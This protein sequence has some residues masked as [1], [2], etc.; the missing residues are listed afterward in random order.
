VKED[1]RGVLVLCPV[2]RS[3][4]PAVSL[5]HGP[6]RIG[7]LLGWEANGANLISTFRVPRGE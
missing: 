4:L 6:T 7:A 2:C 5:S 1:G 3:Q